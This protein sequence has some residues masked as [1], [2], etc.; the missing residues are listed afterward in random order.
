[1]MLDRFPELKVAY[2]LKEYYINMNSTTL[3]SDAPEA[4]DKAIELF[5]CCGIAEYDELYRLL[6]NWREEIVNSFTTINGQRINNSVIESKNRMVEKLL[7][8]SNG[9]TNFKRT[10]NRILYCLNPNDTFTL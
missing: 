8:N 5:E 9:F 3:L 10:R 1:M 7:Y 2:E 4:V 6:N